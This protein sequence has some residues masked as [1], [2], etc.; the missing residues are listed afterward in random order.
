MDPKHTRVLSVPAVR[1]ALWQF[2]V[3]LV[4][5]EAALLTLDVRHHSD[6]SLVCWLDLLTNLNAHGVNE[7]GAVPDAT[8]TLSPSPTGAQPSNGLLHRAV[9]EARG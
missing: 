4:P 2:G 8:L 5:S 7:S 3:Q 9:Y 1:L 6:P